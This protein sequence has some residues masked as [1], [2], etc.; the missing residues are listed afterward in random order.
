MNGRISEIAKGA[1]PVG[2]TACKQRIGL[3]GGV[4]IYKGIQP[5]ISTDI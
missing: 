4:L 5:L 1:A 3:V 2:V